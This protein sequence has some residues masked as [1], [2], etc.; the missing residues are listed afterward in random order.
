MYFSTKDLDAHDKKELHQSA[1]L[2]LWLGIGA[3]V[4]G[5]LALY[6]SFFST[7]ITVFMLGVILMV[8]GI[9]EGIQSLNV[10]KWKNF[11][12]H[13]FLSVIYIVGGGIIV[14]H[15]LVSEINLTLLLA[16]FFIV[17]GLVKAIFAF[18]QH[19]IIHKNWQIFNGIITFILGVLIWMQWPESGLWIIGVFVGINALLTGWSWLMIYYLLKHLR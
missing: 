3:L 1:P 8:M 6:F 11:F 10:R 16:F 19:H 7:L 17:S 2:F 13:L 9:I 14:A 15:P 18:T 5:S 12:L 4:L